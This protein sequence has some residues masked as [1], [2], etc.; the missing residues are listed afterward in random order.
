MDTLTAQIVAARSRG[1]VVTPSWLYEQQRLATLQRQLVGEWDRYAG[2]AQQIITDLQQTAIATARRE[3][4]QLTLAALA[5]AGLAVTA[6]LAQ[7]P[8]GAF[9]DLVGVL[10]D[11]S[12]LRSLLDALGTH[13]AQA[14]GDALLHAVAVGQNPRQ[15]ARQIR[16]A[17]GGDLH[18]ALRIARTEHMR[19]YRSASLRTYQ[20]NGDILRGW[21]WRASPSR[22]TCCV[23]LALDGS[24]HPLDEPFAA[25]VSC[26]CTPVP[27]LR[28]QSAPPHETGADWFARQD[29]ATQRAMLGPGKF[30]LY[31]DGKLALA[32]L[33]GTKDDAR[34][35]R[36][37]YERSLGELKSGREKPAQRAF[38]SNLPHNPPPPPDNLPMA[39]LDLERVQSLRGMERM[40][41]AEMAIVDRPVEYGFGY[42]R[43]GD[44]VINRRGEAQG[45]RPTAEEARQLQGGIF[46]HNHPRN[47][48]FSKYDAQ[49]LHRIQPSELRVIG[50]GDDGVIYRYIVKP[51]TAFFQLNEAVLESVLLRATNIATNEAKKR[52]EQFSTRQAA[53]R[54]HLDRVMRYTDALLRMRYQASMNYVQEVVDG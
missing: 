16:D 12:P 1:E 39:A 17:L 21:M 33:V 7:V 44:V 27:L 24:E 54:W 25:H 45:F 4:T 48:S 10:G 30:D 36:S 20:A 31:R 40:H 43:Q 26:R 22:K 8:L 18:R 9:A 5:D 51:N 38:R 29:E 37:V 42:D 32:D 46:T 3:A 13:A 35:G 49:A 50:R 53:A 52:R 28:N 23:C 34:W 47:G 14:V 11:G 6:E 2:E 41:A 19:A 15:T